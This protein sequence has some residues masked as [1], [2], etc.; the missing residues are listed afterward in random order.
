MYVKV[1]REESLL[2]PRT[3]WILSHEQSC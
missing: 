2:D 3:S 1:L